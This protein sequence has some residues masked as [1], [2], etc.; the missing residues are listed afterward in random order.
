MAPRR[1]VLRGDAEDAEEEDEDGNEGGKEGEEYEEVSCEAG[2]DIM[3]LALFFF[4]FNFLY[5]R[6][7]F[8]NLR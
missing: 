6:N 4:L 8:S 3:S 5:C 1:R 2:R 7:I